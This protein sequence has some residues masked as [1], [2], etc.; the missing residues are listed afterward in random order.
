MP[1]MFI[2]NCRCG[3]E[4]SVNLAGASPEAAELAV[5]GLQWMWQ[6]HAV[7]NKCVKFPDALSVQA[8]RDWKS[9]SGQ[10][11]A[12]FDG[13]P[14]FLKGYRHGMCPSCYQSLR[15]QHLNCVNHGFFAIGY[16]NHLAET[17][18]IPDDG[19]SEERLHSRRCRCGK[20]AVELHRDCAWH[21]ATS[22]E[23]A[24]DLHKR[25]YGHDGTTP[26][27]TFTPE[28]QGGKPDVSDMRTP[29][30]RPADKPQ[31]KHTWAEDQS[32]NIAELISRA[33][34]AA[35]RALAGD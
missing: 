19:I 27:E 22:A 24:N 7:A 21:D 12:D 33:A 5:D 1:E 15:D 34:R 11:A 35:L 17:L 23:Y 8:W 3:W 30:D 31:V 2:Q 32:D 9:T 14:E 25:L 26:H 10:S 6:V 16:A 13:E 18:A 28:T 4:R 20:H 29:D